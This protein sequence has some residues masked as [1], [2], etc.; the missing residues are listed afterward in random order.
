[1]ER[2]N[3]FNRNGRWAV[4]ENG[5]ERNGEEGGW[6]SEGERA[7]EGTAESQHQIKEGSASTILMSI[8]CDLLPDI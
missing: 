2:A 6:A 8:Y 1:M 7:S 5:N 3:K 4:K